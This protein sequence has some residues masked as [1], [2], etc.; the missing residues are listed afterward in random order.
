M[1]SVRLE[2]KIA[3]GE[4][5]LFETETSKAEA[6]GFTHKSAKRSAEATEDGSRHWYRRTAP[7][8]EQVRLPETEREASEWRTWWKETRC[9]TELRRKL[10][11]GEVTVF[12]KK[13]TLKRASV[14]QR[15]V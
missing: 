8:A 3:E 6:Y 9:P 15:E 11:V 7:V 12:L 1:A 14:V 4:E 5:S 13:A 10:F 2:A